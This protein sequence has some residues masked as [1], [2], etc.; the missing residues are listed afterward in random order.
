M[1]EPTGG[2]VIHRR[3]QPEVERCRAP[4]WH[5][6]SGGL[7]PPS[8]TILRPPCHAVWWIFP[9]WH[10]DSLGLPYP[11]AVVPI[12]RYA[13][14]DGRAR[15]VADRQSH[16]GYHRRPSGSKFPVPSHR[17]CYTDASLCLPVCVNT[18]RNHRQPTRWRLDDMTYICAWGKAEG[19]TCPWRSEKL[20]PT[21]L[22]CGLVRAKPGPRERQ[23]MG[24][25]TRLLQC[26][27]K[28]PRRPLRG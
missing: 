7:V 22:R 19:D 27:R 1:A 15:E 16:G 2:R 6:R 26:S 10:H 12:V 4:L 9:V 20:R 24:E 17:V 23:R 8:P 18:Q 5:W 11:T 28:G 3:A 14:H 21:R 25:S 13:E